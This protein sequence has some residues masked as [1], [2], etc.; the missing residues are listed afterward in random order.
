MAGNGHKIEDLR[1]R[2]EQVDSQGGAEQID[3]QHQRGKLTARER[4]QSFFDPGSF[5]EIDAFVEH[6]STNFGMDKLAIAADGVITG[7]GRVEGRPVFSFFQDFTSRGGSLG[8]MHARKISKIQDLALK[9][10][11]PLVGFNDSGGARI[12]STHCAD[13]EISFSATP[14]VPA[15]FPRFRPSWV[16]VPVERSIPRP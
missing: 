7:S 1:R 13:T 9:A 4:I 5:Q 8:E 10:G 2:L 16:R 3:K 6:R 11:C 15:S 14:D 12:Q